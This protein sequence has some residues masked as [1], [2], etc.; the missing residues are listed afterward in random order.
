[1][2]LITFSMALTDFFE[3]NQRIHV[4]Y[5]TQNCYWLSEKHVISCPNSDVHVMDAYIYFCYW[6][7]AVMQWPDL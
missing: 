4:L 2:L 7:A 3:N 1:M 6:Q 5:F